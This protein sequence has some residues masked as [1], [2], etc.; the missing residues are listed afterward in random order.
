LNLSVTPNYQIDEE[1]IG[2][3]YHEVFIENSDETRAEQIITYTIGFIKDHQFDAT[4][5]KG[6]EKTSVKYGLTRAE[7][8]IDLSGAEVDRSKP[9]DGGE[10]LL[11]IEQDVTEKHAKID[12]V[13]NENSGELDIQ[14]TS[15]GGKAG[16]KVTEKTAL[17]KENQEEQSVTYKSC[18]ITATANL[19]KLRSPSWVFSS[20]R[21]VLCGKLEKRHLCH[22]REVDEINFYGNSFIRID[23]RDI[24]VFS[25]P[26][27]PGIIGKLRGL[28]DK[29]MKK[30]IANAIVED[31]K[32]PQPIRNLN[33]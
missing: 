18:H 13:A 1:N 15:T 28:G 14:T 23:A 20:H 21:G 5:K 3:F 6:A 26:T 33:D 22:V 16:A 9:V 12:K 30:T 31:S 10:L 7:L 27:P 4:F 24:Q 2:G 25:Y 17:E 32:K 8:C 11:E 19:R 29:W